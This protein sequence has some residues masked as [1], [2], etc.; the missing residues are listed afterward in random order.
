MRGHNGDQRPPRVHARCEHDLARGRVTAAP[1]G[2]AGPGCR[3]AGL[4]FRVYGWFRV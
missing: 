3:A 1:P 2:P 4:G